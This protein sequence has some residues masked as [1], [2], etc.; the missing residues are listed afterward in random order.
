MTTPKT[1]VA[2]EPR[3]HKKYERLIAATEN[4]PSLPAAVAHPCD[5]TSLRGT[6]EAAAGGLIAPILVGPKGRIRAV[7]ETLA[8]D[9]GGMEIVDVPHS[10]AA[11]EKAVELVRTGRA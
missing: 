5:E 1:A 3:K 2:L 10:E 8:I 7:S 11:A 4:L 6:L 9:L